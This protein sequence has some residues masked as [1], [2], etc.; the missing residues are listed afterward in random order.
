MPQLWPITFQVGTFTIYTLFSSPV[1]F[2]FKV[3]SELH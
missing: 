1:Q 2:K 3:S